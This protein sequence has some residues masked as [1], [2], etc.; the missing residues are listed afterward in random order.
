MADTNQ[1]RRSDFTEFSDN[2][3]FAELTRIMG[4]APRAPESAKPVAQDDFDL[5]LDLEKELMG[6]LDFREF[7]EPKSEEPEAQ[8]PESEWQHAAEAEEEY[9]PAQHYSEPQPV[10]AA[11][12][13]ID[14][15]MAAE[16]FVEDEVHAFDP[17]PEMVEDDAVETALEPEAVA[18]TS[19]EPVQD[20]FE[21]SL[22]RELVGDD[23]PFEAP[24]EEPEAFE[25]ETYEGG[26]YNASEAPRTEEPVDFGPG[27]TS[28][29]Y[30]Q[31]D[32]GM[33]EVDMDFGMLEQEL[34]AA[35]EPAMA[36]S[37]AI[38]PAA[39][40]W[41]PEPFAESEPE[42]TSREESFG[43][44]FFAPAD[45]TEPAPEESVAAELSLEDELSALLGEGSAQ[46]EAAHEE[47]QPIV[48][49]AA[50][51]AV[52]PVD[53]WKPAVS[54]FGRSNFAAM[55]ETAPAAEPAEAPVAET[56]TAE[57]YEAEE[58]PFEAEADTPLEDTFAEIFGL[59]SEPEIKEPE[60]Q[61]EMQ[62]QPEASGVEA[63]ATWQPERT[64]SAAAPVAAV[65][66]ASAAP[67]IETIDVAESAQA[68][69]DDLD[70]PEP[71][72][73][74][75]APSNGLYDDLEGE[76][77]Q[78]FGDMSMDEPA[79]AAQPSSAPE[80]GVAA[81]AT[82]AAAYAATAA[83]SASAA[84]ASHDH[85]Q[86][87]A[88]AY[89]VG[90]G[91]WQTDNGFADDDFNYETDL[92]Q[93]IAMSS[94]EDEP[95]ARTYPRNRN[96]MIAAVV[97]GVAVVGGVGVFAMSLFGGGSDEPAI[98]RA[99]DDPMKVRPE[100]PGGTTVPNQDNEVYQRVT[101]GAS[102]AAPEQ[103]R[104]ISTSEEP[105]NIEAGSEQQA[106]LPS[107]I[108]EAV[109]EPTAA[110]NDTAAGEQNVAAAAPKADDR[111]EPVAEAEGVG[112]SNDV[113]AVAPR[114]VRTMVV[115]SDGTMVPREDPTPAQP[116][117]TNLAA[118]TVGD[119]Q[120]LAPAGADA[121]DEGPS[122]ETPATVSVVPS[123]RREP[124][125]T[126]A[127]APQQPVVQ[128]PATQTPA[129]TPV[130]APAAAAPAAGASAWS[131]QIASQPTA[132]GAQ[133]TYQDL[134]RR[135]GNVLEGRGVNIVRADIDGLGTYYRVRI[136]ANTRDEAIQLCTRYKAAGGSCFVSR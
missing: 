113:L 65:A 60:S 4:H 111:I 93:A 85:Q 68:M 95:V 42:A 56:L 10:E 51:V 69:V 26:A 54:T 78:A 130:S 119:A 3:P 11:D 114:R 31:G 46:P 131:M 9:Q 127:A 41:Q 40:D 8:A 82:G 117:Q 62:Q 20:D 99:G 129:A 34:A 58:A 125:Q 19:P 39:D 84:Q 134:A 132:E 50:P 32:D 90:E 70:I 97:A 30:A 106:A 23:A 63:L 36:P 15:D 104:L 22:E 126:A 53:D 66:A 29:A 59:D 25:A 61:P 38:D 86:P 89:A 81:A 100:N 121:Q 80:W 73:G 120:P 1:S 115:R 12:A 55:R 105:V 88:D 108:G 109:E 92:E 64:F 75:P 122:V 57:T 52:A 94:Y 124:Q 35:V 83:S 123:Q 98:V 72:Y 118:A 77:A 37:R 67:D 91:Q 96:L 49:P 18:A 133:A 28:P 16:A 14:F 2:D 17:E 112:A 87:S 27:E 101:G 21:M 79:P 47:P 45:E 5:D 48:M 43:P 136:P 128:Q 102:D 24:S 103:E 44:V 135:Y 110:G 13:S 7:D 76:I 71:D 33:A 6:D 116:E 107:A 74:A